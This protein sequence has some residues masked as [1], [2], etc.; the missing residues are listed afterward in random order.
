MK[1]AAIKGEGET[2][3]PVASSHLYYY[4]LIYGVASLAKTAAADTANMAAVG[5]AD[6]G[7]DSF[8]ALETRDQSVIGRGWRILR[9]FGDDYC[10]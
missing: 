6:C 1:T 5:P 3:D 2:K 10:L 8:L 7:E 4:S 9:I